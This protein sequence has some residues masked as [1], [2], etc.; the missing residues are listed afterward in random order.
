MVDGQLGKLYDL[1]LRVRVAKCRGNP[2]GSLVFG[3]AIG[4]TRLEHDDVRVFSAENP[5][6]RA[7]P[8]EPAPMIM[9]STMS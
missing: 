6:A 3:P 4:R 8:A 5:C 9:W 2:A 7:Q 1:G